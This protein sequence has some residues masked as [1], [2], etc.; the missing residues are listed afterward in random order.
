MLGPL[1][2][3]TLGTDLTTVPQFPHL[4]IVSVS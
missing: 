4:L 3:G 2:P 1:P